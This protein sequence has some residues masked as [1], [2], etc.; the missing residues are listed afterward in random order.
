MHLE[1]LDKVLKIK[2]N[3]SHSDVADAMEKAGI[4]MIKKGAARKK[5]EKKKEAKVKENKISKK[6]KKK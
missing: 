4:K 6:E 3:A 1:P 2:K 5:A